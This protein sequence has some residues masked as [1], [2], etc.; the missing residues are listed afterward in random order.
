MSGF[1]GAPFENDDWLI[2]PA[3]D[4]DNY[5]NEV[6]TFQ[7]AKNY[8]GNDLEV[9]ISIDYDGGGNPYSGTWTTLHSLSPLEIGN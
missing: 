5:I 1:E 8:T 6:L 3:L 2:S 7:N 9:K 4:L